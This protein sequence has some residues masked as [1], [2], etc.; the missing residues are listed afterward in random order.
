MDECKHAPQA[1]GAI[2]AADDLCLE[3]GQEAGRIAGA[4]EAIREQLLDLLDD[5]VDQLGASG[6]DGLDRLPDVGQQ[7]YRKVPGEVEE[8]SRRLGVKLTSGSRPG[9]SSSPIRMAASASL[10]ACL[11][12]TDAITSYSQDGGERLL[13]RLESDAELGRGALEEADDACGTH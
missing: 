6:E 8:R 9:L 4:D 13:E 10:S 7:A 2:R 5:R 11:F 3:A 12:M 1:A